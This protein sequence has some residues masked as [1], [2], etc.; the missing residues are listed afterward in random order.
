MK[1]KQHVRFGAGIAL[2]CLLGWGVSVNGQVKQ[3]FELKDLTGLEFLQTLRSFYP[4][5]SR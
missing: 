5:R 2:V 4:L 3:T 1:T